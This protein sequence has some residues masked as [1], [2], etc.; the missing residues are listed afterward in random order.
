MQLKPEAIQPAKG[1]E[2]FKSIA[3]M[4][5]LEGII[6]NQFCI[7]KDAPYRE[8]FATKKFIQFLVNK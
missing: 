7:E 4:D 8:F 6:F 2:L 5:E 3:V 1:P